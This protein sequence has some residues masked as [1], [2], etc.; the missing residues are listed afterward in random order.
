MEKEQTNLTLRKDL[1]NRAIGAV[2]NGFF[3]GVNSLT[4]LV[5]KALEEL[6]D[7]SHV[8]KTFDEVKQEA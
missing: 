5:E 6:L 7:R 4:G 1:K 3:T 2:N 8:P